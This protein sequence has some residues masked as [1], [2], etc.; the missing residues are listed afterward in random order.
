MLVMLALEA[1]LAK[2]AGRAPGGGVLAA[3]PG[4]SDDG[5]IK[6]KDKA[7]DDAMAEEEAATERGVE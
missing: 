1:K 6:G 5:E 7:E 2:P 4:K 3:E